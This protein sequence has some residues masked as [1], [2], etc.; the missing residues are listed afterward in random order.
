[1][2]LGQILIVYRKELRD[3]LRDRR[4]LVSMIVIPLIL[5]PFL[6]IGMTTM[7]LKLIK[8]AQEEASTVMIF[9]EDQA[10]ALAEKIRSTEGIEVVPPAD[11]YVHR[12][13]E[14]KLRAALEFPE[15]FQEL[16]ETGSAPDDLTVK[17]YHY[18][19]E[20]RSSFAVRN[21]QKILRDYRDEV[22]EERLAKRDL[23][24][25]IL[26][27]FQTREQ[28]VASPEKVGGNIMG[29]LLPYII[30]LLSLTGAMYPA[31][32]LTA[33]EKERGTMETILASPV[34]RGS[35]ATGKF[36]TVLTASVATALLAILSLATTLRLAPSFTDL[37]P[38]GDIPIFKMALNVQGV[39]AIIA[40]IL[41]LAVLFSATLLAIAL[42]AKSY[43]EAQSYISPLM[44][45]VIL[46]SVASMLP[47]IELDSRLV[48]IPILNVSL[49]CKEIL[50]G[51]FHWNWILLIFLS[52]SIY[53]A[54][55]LFIAA[56]AFQRE[57]VLF[58][59]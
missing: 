56:R 48:W 1:M 35:L 59:T 34:S 8:K 41:P 51:T 3:T 23:S 17:I 11:D 9:G 25:E 52:S 19:G 12:I 44:I 27:P 4:T 28:N 18:E 15:G 30:I 49:V 32:D 2:N 38:R 29:G 55:A 43:K 39:T 45:V 54:V 10:P 5:M 58:R 16:L 46:P 13:E 47:G 26:K 57:S 42:L 33:G 40:M 22:V 21:L 50:T 36:L 7:S 31:I 6:I 20:M 37:G 53:A 14:K 24:I